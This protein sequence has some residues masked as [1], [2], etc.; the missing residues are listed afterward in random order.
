M[1][2]RSGLFYNLNS[3]E[4]AVQMQPTAPPPPV[5]YVPGEDTGGGGGAALPPPAVAELLDQVTALQEGKAPQPAGG[6][7]NGGGGPEHASAEATRA[8]YEEMVLAA[9]ATL[10][11][12]QAYTSS[13]PSAPPPA[14]FGAV[15]GIEKAEKNVC[16]Q[17]RIGA[18]LAGKDFGH[19]EG[20][21]SAR[22]C[23]QECS[24]SIRCRGFP[25]IDFD[26]ASHCWRLNKMKVIGYDGIWQGMFR[27]R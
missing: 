26:Y 22:D 15:S 7:G 20:V 24:N 27:Y 12:P 1:I 11:Q 8:S 14:G 19:I 16:C 21:G 6:G 2:L 17:A 4:A 13:V 9:A 18:D 23:C 10:P 3:G 25:A 5:I